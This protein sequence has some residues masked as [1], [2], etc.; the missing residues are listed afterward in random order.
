MVLPYGFPGFI[1]EENWFNVIRVSMFCDQYLEFPIVSRDQLVCIKPVSILVDVWLPCL[2]II[3]PPWYPIHYPKICVDLIITQL[4][5]DSVIVYYQLV[6]E[7]VVI[8]LLN[9]TIPFLYLLRSVTFAWT[10]VIS[11]NFHDCRFKAEEAWFEWFWL[12][13]SSSSDQFLTQL[14]K[15]IYLILV[16]WRAILNLFTCYSSINL[17][18]SIVLFIALE[19]NWSILGLCYDMTVC[20]HRNIIIY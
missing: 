7:L 2:C 1:A 10:S 5:C 15:G 14:L 9:V 16:S 19:L 20:K 3:D 18:F 4:W 13:Q 17:D 6:F 12:I 8:N 11:V